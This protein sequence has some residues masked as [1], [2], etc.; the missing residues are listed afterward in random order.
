M[1]SPL[2]ISNHAR[3]RWIQRITD[4]KRYKHL[5]LCKGC[6]TCNSLIRD[7]D[8]VVRFSG[9]YVDQEIRKRF[10]RA[11]DNN[12]VVTDPQV[13]LALKKHFPDEELTLFVDKDAVFVVIYKPN[14]FLKSVITYDMIEGT[15]FFVAR[16]KDD[17]KS[18][19]NRWN[20]EMR[21]RR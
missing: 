2:A 8:R 21:L 7:I 10:K 9:G 6:D 17:I 12:R 16:T 5:D 20:A 4:P 3:E 1:D 14:P 11:K 15:L 13:K 18:V 19:F